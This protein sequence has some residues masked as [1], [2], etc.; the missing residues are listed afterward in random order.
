MRA[1][2]MQERSQIQPLFYKAPL[3]SLTA[4]NGIHAKTSRPRADFHL[5]LNIPTEIGPQYIDLES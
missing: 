3:L 2:T 4:S 1:M 5:S